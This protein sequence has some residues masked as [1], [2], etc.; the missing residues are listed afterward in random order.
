MNASQIISQY[1]QSQGMNPNAALTEVKKV[2]DSPNGYALQEGNSVFILERIGKGSVGI[3]LFTV[4]S[5]QALMGSIKSAIS[6]V[7]NSGVSKIYG[8]SENQELVDA[9]SQMGIQIGKSDNP[10]YSWS[11]SI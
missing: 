10:D 5:A 8:E 7:K 1:A 3:H 2:I 4:D 6:K 11:A 9:L